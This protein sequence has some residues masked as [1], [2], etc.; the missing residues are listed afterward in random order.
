MNRNMKRIKPFTLFVI[1][2]ASLIVISFSSCVIVNF[3]SHYGGRNAVSGRGDPETYEIRVGQFS[4]I[5]VEGY[6]DVRYYAA[7]RDY[8]TLEVQPNLR[9]YFVVE[10]I[11]DELLLRTTRRIN[12]G[13]GKTPVLTVYTSVLEGL[14]IEG[15]GTFT[16]QDK[17]S[18][19]SFKLRL[20]G[21][22]K[23]QAEFDVNELYVSM[24]GAGSLELSGLADRVS[25]DMSG[26]GELNA[27][28]LQ[29]RE[30]AVKFSGAGAVKISC[31][32]DLSITASGVGSV[33]YRGSPRV[34]LSNSGLVSVN[35]VD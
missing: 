25:L 24:S 23:G 34:S 14:N 20:A 5:K 15:A 9:E 11:G 2:Y 1:L 18:T 12:Y 35:R 10:V 21:A 6:C 31:S 26:A 7:A 4:R 17:I 16:T 13:S 28:S 19:D 32:E 3:D 27:L 22:G 33:E 29:S 8:V 30:A